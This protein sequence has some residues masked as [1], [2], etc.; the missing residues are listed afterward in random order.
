MNRWTETYTH[1]KVDIFDPD[2]NSICI[3][4]IAHHLSIINRF[5]GAIREPYSVAQHSVIL[6]SFFG[7]EKTLDFDNSGSKLYALQALLHDSAEAY[8]GDIPAPVKCAL[9]GYKE[10][11]N[12]LLKI[13]FNK[14]RVRW[15]LYYAIDVRDKQLCREEGRQL[16]KDVDMWHNYAEEEIG[17]LPWDIDIIPWNWRQAEGAFLTSFK[18]LTECWY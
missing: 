8:I 3:E 18:R 13:I 14:F 17:K 6:S 11:E 4:D 1:K 7:K 2:P 16:G 10:I 9:N 15:P 5:A 12:N